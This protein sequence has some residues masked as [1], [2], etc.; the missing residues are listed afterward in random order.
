MN[1]GG[2]TRMLIDGFQRLL[3][4]PATKHLSQYAEGKRQQHPRP[5]HFARHD[6]HNGLP[7]LAAIH[8]IKDA[9]TK[10]QR[11]QNLQ[12]NVSQLHSGDKDTNKLR[13]S[14]MFLAFSE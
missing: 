7:V 14:Q 4:A 3:P 6:V 9:R 13:K 12:Y 10:Y 1:A 5:V 11:H 2:N 8:P